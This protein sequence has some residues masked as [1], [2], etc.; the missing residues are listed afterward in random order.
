MPP[1]ENKNNNLTDVNS[2]KIGID[3][4]FKGVPNQQQNATTPNIGAGAFNILNNQKYTPSQTAPTPQPI[5][6]ANPNSPKSIVRTYKGDLE[7]A[8]QNNHLSS[9]NIAIAENQK[10]HNQIQAEQKQPEVAAP[11]EYSKNKIIIFISVI[12]IALGIIGVIVAFILTSSGSNPVAQVQELPALITTEY[13]DELSLNTVPKGKLLEILS[14][15]LNDS[16]ITVNKLYNTYITSGTSTSRK[17]ITAGEFAAQTGFNMPDILKRT[18]LPDYMLGAY[19]FGKNLPF[20]IFKSTYFENAYAGMLSWEINLKKDLLILFRLPGYEN[21][22]GLIADLTP[23]DNKKF[24]DGVIVNKDVRILKDE[25]NNVILLYGIIDKETIIITVN[26]TAFK[27]IIN[28]L[29]KE[30]SLKR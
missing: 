26:D 23:T 5:P 3:P 13:K 18:L 20:I 11:S 2:L 28:R 10:M 1:K 4:V 22:G 15:K 6:V 30:K 12:L 8:I 17:L 29:N 21:G 9:I 16:Q 7:S 19:S 27:E 24:E 25:K 14:A